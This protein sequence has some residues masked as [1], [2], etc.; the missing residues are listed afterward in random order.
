MGIFNRDKTKV[1]TT[2]PPDNL[3]TP[4]YISQDD[5]AHYRDPR[6]AN[7][8]RLE[9]VKHIGRKFV[10]Q[11]EDAPDVVHTLPW[12]RGNVG[13]VKENVIEYLLGLFPFLQWMPRY[14]LQWLIG[15]LIA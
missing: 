5:D 2:N 1:G 10:G 6:L 4:A 9:K 12:L 7:R 14:N 13:N 11:P 3:F 8:D 15:D